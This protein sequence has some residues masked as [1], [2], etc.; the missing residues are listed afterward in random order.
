MTGNTPSVITTLL[1][2]VEIGIVLRLLHT[3]YFKPYTDVTTTLL[4]KIAL[5]LVYKIGFFRGMAYTI[6][7][8]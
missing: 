6:C 8:F 3:K 5:K 7:L 4:H 2:P 1:Q